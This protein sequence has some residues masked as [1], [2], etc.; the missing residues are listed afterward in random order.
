MARTIMDAVQENVNPVTV[1]NT[2]YEMML[3]WRNCVILIQTGQAKSKSKL[4]HKKQ[5]IERYLAW[6][7]GT[8]GQEIRALLNKHFEVES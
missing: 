2:I 4:R 1:S 8:D 5:L 3:D 6:F 7:M